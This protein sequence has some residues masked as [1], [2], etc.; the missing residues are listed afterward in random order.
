MKYVFLS[1]RADF[2]LKEFLTSLG[3]I[4]IEIKDSGKV[5]KEISDHPDIYLCLIDEHLI[6]A[7]DQLE[8]ISDQLGPGFESL[9][10]IPGSKPVGEIYP[11]SA[12]YNGV[13]VGRFFIHN[14]SYTDDSIIEAVKKSDLKIIDIKQ[15][16][17][18][19]NIVAVDN[20]S[21]ITSDAGIFRTIREN[22]PQI[23]V[24]KV[25]LGHVRL[26]GFEYGF[27]GGSSGQIDDYIIFNGNLEDHPDFIIIKNFIKSK[28]LKLKYFKEYPLTD[29]GSI[30]GF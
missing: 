21:I 26:H 6:V 7:R 9:N 18:N 4:V 8:N 25:S 30:I 3:K 20:N 16:Y 11:A 24:L 14:T 2:K 13:Q 27:L 22:Y 10:I 29:I 28:N 19:C 23:D 12:I 15:G 17:A 5:Y 1:N